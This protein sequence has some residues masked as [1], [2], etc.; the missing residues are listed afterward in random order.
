[1]GDKILDVRV[2]W[3]VKSDMPAVLDIETATFEFAWTEKDFS[4]CLGKLNCIGL[5]AESLDDGIL[6]G[7]VV[8]DRHRDHIDILN[9]AVAHV[10]R[11]QNVGAQML[12]S[13]IAKLYYPRLSLRCEVRET[14][15]TAQLFLRRYGFRAIR[16]LRGWYDDS[17]EDAYAMHYVAGSKTECDK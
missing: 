1:M 16:V 13:L 6:T 12:R 9:M 3:M 8:Y 4:Q 2:R 7:Y 11:R 10:F 14:N 15:L 17:D 5:V